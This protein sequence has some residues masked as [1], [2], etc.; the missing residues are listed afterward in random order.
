MTNTQH[1]EMDREFNERMNHVRAVVSAMEN[2]GG[3][4]DVIVC[5]ICRNFRVVRKGL[6]SDC[7]T[8]Q[9]VRGDK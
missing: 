3:C 7:P 8:C 2:S 6:N 5:P 4:E 9:A 1:A